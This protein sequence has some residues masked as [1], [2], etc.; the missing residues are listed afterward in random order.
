VQWRTIRTIENIIEKLILLKHPH[1]CSKVMPLK[2]LH[3]SSGLKMSVAVEK[4][5]FTYL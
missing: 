5:L 1:D 4:L 2:I 3:S